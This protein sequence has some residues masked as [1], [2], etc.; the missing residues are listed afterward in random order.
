MAGIER[1]ILFRNKSVSY[2]NPA[3]SPN[4]TLEIICLLAESQEKYTPDHKNPGLGVT[5]SII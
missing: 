1:F 5:L 2:I 3:K 4:S